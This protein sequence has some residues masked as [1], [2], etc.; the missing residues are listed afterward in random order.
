M[1]FPRKTYVSELALYLDF[2]NDESYTPSKISVNVGNSTSDLWEV[3]T[4]ELDEPLGW[5]NFSLGTMKGEEFKVAK[6]HLA[7]FVVLQN[8]HNGR[9]THIRQVKLFGPREDFET[10]FGK[11]TSEEYIKYSYLR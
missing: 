10:P 8:Q 9:D 2:K 4:V 3:Q 7:Q 6:I 1:Y 5:F 11:L